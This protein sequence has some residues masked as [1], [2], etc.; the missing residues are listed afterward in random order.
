MPRRRPIPP[1][2]SL[3]YS[4]NPIDAFWNIPQQPRPARPENCLHYHRHYELLYILNGVREF[5][6]FGKYYRAE[7]GDL[8][9][10]RPEEAHVEFSGTPDI[11]YFVFRFRS[12]ELSNAR[13]EFPSVRSNRP[14]L[15]L[16][17]KHEFLDLFNQMIEE[18]RNPGE[19]SQTLLSS[20]LSIFLIKLRRAASESGLKAGKMNSPIHDRV[21]LA[22]HL[23]QK[24]VS[25]SATLRNLAQKTFMSVSHLAHT[26][27]EQVGESPRRFQIHERIRLAR[28]LL[29]E[30]QKPATE[31]AE[32]LGYKSPYFFYRQFH[33]KTSM[34]TAEF[35]E[36]FR[37]R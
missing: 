36:R 25:Q 20:Y 9:I 18:F 33:A 16:P 24:N 31:I 15:N 35:R 4:T 30:T 3:D 10:F 6:F 34:T 2:V 17:H 23:L 21:Q 26:F 8:I 27:K 28:T 29:L 11:S 22:A 19:N 1:P 32:Q 14:L 7:T 12:D 37:S 13:L 5:Y